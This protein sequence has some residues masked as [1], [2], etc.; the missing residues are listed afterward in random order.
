VFREVDQ[1]TDEVLTLRALVRQRERLVEDKVRLTNRLEDLI[2]SYFP[3]LLA[4]TSDL[5]QRWFLQLLQWAACPAQARK[6]SWVKVRNLLQKHRV[7]RIDATQVRRILA[8]DPLPGVNLQAPAASFEVQG[9]AQPVTLVAEQIQACEKRMAQ[10]IVTLS[11]AVAGS[12]EKDAGH[13]T[14]HAS[15]GSIQFSDVNLLRSVP[16][17]GPYAL[18]VLLAE[19]AMLLKY[20]DYQALRALSGVAPVTKRSGKKHVVCQRYA[21]NRLLQKAL[22]HWAHNASLRDPICRA[23]YQSLRARGKTRGHA[24]RCVGDRLLNVTCSMLRS[25]T[26]F[27]AAPAVV[28]E[29]A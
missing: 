6:L 2:W 23:K 1:L 22:F 3:A 7:R 20:R 24:L 27:A 9:L 10:I 21:V 29:P 19:A 4:L 26:L 11:A 17:L 12:T 18:A 16:G 25:N 28:S 5:G 8:Q 15:S 14:D 13:A